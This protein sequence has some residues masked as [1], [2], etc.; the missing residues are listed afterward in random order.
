MLWAM[1]CDSWRILKTITGLQSSAYFAIYKALRRMEY[2][3][4]LVT[5]ST[6]V[7]TRTHTGLAT[8][9]TASQVYTIRC[10]SE[11]GQQ[12]TTKCV[13]LS[14]SEAEYIDLSLAVQE[15]KWIHRLP[16]EIMT[17]ANKD[18]PELMIYEDNQSCIKM[19]K[20]P[21]NHGHTKLIDIKYH[22]ICD[23]TSSVMRSS[24]AKSSSS[25][26]V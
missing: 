2:A 22:H 10:A 19:T 13:S 1:Y 6:F 20:N 7:D 4:S 14:K 25:R 11:L 15:G 26:L 24:A 23:D 21:V 16:C 17:A 12:E 9:P 5:R 8:S 3:T 18:G